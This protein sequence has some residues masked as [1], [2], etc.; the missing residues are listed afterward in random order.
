MRKFTMQVYPIRPDFTFVEGD[1]TTKWI[2]PLT[3]V[4]YRVSPLLN[5][6]NDWLIEM[7]GLPVN[8]KNTYVA[9]NVFKYKCK[10][11]GEV[12]RFVSLRENTDLKELL[13][14]RGDWIDPDGV[15]QGQG[16]L[17]MLLWKVIKNE[18]DITLCSRNF[19]IVCKEESK[20]WIGVGVYDD[21][22]LFKTLPYETEKMCKEESVNQMIEF[23]KF[24]LK[25]F[26]DLFWNL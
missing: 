2:S 16:R 13:K 10:T 6:D 9:D 19:K 1:T 17:Q 12:E 26:D 22:A 11:M 8:E 14:A 15:L 4:V 23:L 21:M 3:G 20:G 24:N 7:T 18:D 5:E 25:G